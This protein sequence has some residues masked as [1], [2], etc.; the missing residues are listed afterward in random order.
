MRA[1][2][3]IGVIIGGLSCLVGVIKLYQANTR[4]KDG[5]LGFGLIFLMIGMASVICCG[6]L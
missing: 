1:L 5:D 2:L 6:L 4:N 3:L